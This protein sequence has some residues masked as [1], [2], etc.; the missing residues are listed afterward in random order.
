MIDNVCCIYKSIYID[1][2]VSSRNKIKRSLYIY[3]LYASCVEYNS[4][5]DIIETLKDNQLSIENYNKALLKVEDE[6]K[7]FLNPNMSKQYKKIKD[8]WGDTK[9][10]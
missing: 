1:R 10:K 4:E 9:I 5:F 8:N 3:C 6:N 2:N 7:L